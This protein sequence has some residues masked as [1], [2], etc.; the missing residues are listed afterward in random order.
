V[1][2]SGWWK[3]KRFRQWTAAGIPAYTSRCHVSGR[4]FR[5]PSLPPA[6]S[7]SSSPPSSPPSFRRGGEGRRVGGPLRN[8]SP[9]KGKQRRVQE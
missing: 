2:G 4:T 6:S 7:S 8:C 5:P 3:T 1:R 9:R